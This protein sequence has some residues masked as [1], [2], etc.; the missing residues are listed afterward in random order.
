MVS[1]KVNE[2][3]IYG[4]CIVERMNEKNRIVCPVILSVLHIF[5]VVE[6]KTQKMKQVR[7]NYNEKP[8]LRPTLWTITHLATT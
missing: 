4:G 7:I 1:V 2:L 6:N 8:N 5:H 3:L